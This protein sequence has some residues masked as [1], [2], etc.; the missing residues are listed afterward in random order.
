MLD[1][2]FSTELAPVFKKVN[3]LDVKVTAAEKK[4]TE[5]EDISTRVNNLKLNSLPFK[6]GEDQNG[7]DNEKRSILLTFATEFHKL[8]FLKRLK[9]KSADMLR[10]IFTGSANDKIHIYFQHDFTSTQYQLL[11]L[12]MTL[13][14]Q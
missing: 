10:G 8:E 13:L 1:K 6:E 3:E 12:S 7:A 5:S 14:K 4:I 2:E 9:S 11:K